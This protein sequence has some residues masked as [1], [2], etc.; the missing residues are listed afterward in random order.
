MVAQEPLLVGLV[1]YLAGGVGGAIAGGAS[2]LVSVGQDIANYGLQ[3]KAM[4]ENAP[5]TIK[6]DGND[7]GTIDI[8]TYGIYFYSMEVTSDVLPLMETEYYA[9]GF[10]TSFITTI[11]SLAL[12]DNAIYGKCK[13]V[14]GRMVDM[15]YNYSITARISDRI[16]AG[17]F[18]LKENQ[19]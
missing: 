7:F 1:V 10:P 18:M 12:E 16:R 11:D 5:D 13:F 19:I 3:E 2:G 6:G 8:N 9:K 4:K 15:V 17:V 14:S